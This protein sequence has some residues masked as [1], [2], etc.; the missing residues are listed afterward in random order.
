[1]GILTEDMKRVISEQRLGFVATVCP[2]GPHF[3]SPGAWPRQTQPTTITTRTLA[4]SLH[5]LTNCKFRNAFVLIFIQNAG[6][7]RVSLQPQTVR[8][9]VS[10]LGPG[11]R[12]SRLP[13]KGAAIEVMRE[14]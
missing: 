9:V 6:G 14:S 2:D 4:L 7:G 12:K 13:G 5:A 10:S 3:G 8:S 1:M 11:A